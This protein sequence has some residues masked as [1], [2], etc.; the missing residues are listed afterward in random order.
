MVTRNRWTRA[1]AASSCDAA[2]QPQLARQPVWRQ[3]AVR[4][5]SAESATQYSAKPLVRNRGRACRCHPA[6][7]KAKETRYESIGAVE[8]FKGGAVR[9]LAHAVRRLHALAAQL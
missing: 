5:S 6:A 8:S 9:Q 7:L 2:Q 1:A 4:A 3:S